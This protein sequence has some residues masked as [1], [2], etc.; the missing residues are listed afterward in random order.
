M[1]SPSITQHYVFGYG[2][3][4][5][6]QSRAISV[7]T[8]A[9]RSALPVRINNL[10]RTWNK[11]SVESGTTF[12]GV[13]QLR[14]TTPALVTTE[15]R[16]GCACVGVLIP[17]DS[18]SLEKCRQELTA[19]DQREVG[20]DR[21]LV[22]L[23]WIHRVDDLLS[24]ED[25]TNNNNNNNNNDDRSNSNGK[26]NND[27][28]YKGTFLDHIPNPVSAAV[29]TYVPHVS[30]PASMDYPIAQSYVDI[31]LKGC[32][33]ISEAFLDEFVTSTVGWNPQEMVDFEMALSNN[34]DAGNDGNNMET[35]VV[36][37]TVSSKGWY[38][39]YCN[40]SSLS[41]YT[42]TYNNMMMIQGQNGSLHSRNN[43]DMSSS[44][45]SSAMEITGNVML[46]NSSLSAAASR[47]LPEAWVDDRSDPIYKRAD[48]TFSLKNATLLDDLLLSSMMRTSTD[49]DDDDKENSGPQQEAAT[50][51]ATTAADFGTKE[52]NS[53]YWNQLRVTRG[54][55]E[56]RAI[57]RLRRQLQSSSEEQS[58]TDK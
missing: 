3:L 15:F 12:L 26:S 28:V 39:H 6:A 14:T 58:K 30:T 46:D 9:T 33:D 41:S 5:C 51:A 31:C 55:N 25:D 44:S 1:L 8:L 38:H 43:S 2:S 13:Q 27:D 57:R 29:W 20:Y 45:W 34:L 48:Q 32:L 54:K 49:D 23:P 18:S 7:P 16:K 50:T 19:L 56:T 37:E 22:P 53:F 47:Q 35:V 17:L 42:P 52:K 24:Y 36:S 10:V 4:I 40:S 21:Q 11:R